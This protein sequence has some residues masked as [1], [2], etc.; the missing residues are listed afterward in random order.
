MHLIKTELNVEGTRTGRFRSD[1][2]QRSNT[3]K[4]GER[5]PGHLTN[6]TTHRAANDDKASLGND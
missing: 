4:P 5:R 2:L 3:P 6:R 1:V